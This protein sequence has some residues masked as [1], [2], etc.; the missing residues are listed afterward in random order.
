MGVSE[1]GLHTPQK[2]GLFQYTREHDDEPVDGIDYPIF[3]QT[4]TGGHPSDCQSL[5]EKA[6]ALDCSISV[7]LLALQEVERVPLGGSRMGAEDFRSQLDP[8]SMARLQKR[9]AYN[10][11][12]YSVSGVPGRS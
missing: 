11:R 9:P 8:P 5:M 6:M 12:S 3:R 1:N 7:N 10:G 4:Q 2:M